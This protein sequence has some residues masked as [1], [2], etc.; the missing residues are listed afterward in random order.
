MSPPT[1]P[2]PLK[3]PLS[4][5]EQLPPH[6]RQRL[7]AVL[8]RLRER[9][10]MESLARKEAGDDREQPRAPVRRRVGVRLASAHYLCE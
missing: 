8:S 5:W 3:Q 1:V 4:L 2:P 7:L 6:H 9:Q 10:L